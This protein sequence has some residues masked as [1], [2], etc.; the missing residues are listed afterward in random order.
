MLNNRDISD[1]YTITL[2]NK[3]DGLQEISETVTPNDEYENFVNA[4][5]EAAAECIPTKLRAKHRVSLETLAVKKKCDDMKA[6]SLSNK[7]NSTDA[8]AQKLSAEAGGLAQVFDKLTTELKHKQKLL[9]CKSTIQIA[10][11]NVRT[12]NRMG[13]QA[14]LTASAV[15][16]NID[17][18]NAQS[19]LTNA[20][21]KEQTKY[22]QLQINKIRY[23]VE[24]RQPRIVWQ[25]VN[26]VSKRKST[27]R[28]KLKAASQEERIRLW[29]EHF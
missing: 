18:K 8:N 20:Y 25:T 10:I 19:E 15:E 9:K 4:H 27:A 22:I 28:A 2:R 3:F 12:L 14:E 17:R 13:L 11:F 29:K 16:H 6:A 24:D 26:E 5:M 21:L 1:K 7:R 23:S